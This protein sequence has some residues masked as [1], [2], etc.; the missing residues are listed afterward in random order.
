MSSKRLM[1]KGVVVCL[2]LSIEAALVNVP[3]RLRLAMTR[4]SFMVMVFEEV[5]C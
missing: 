2:S 1:V 4:V 3:A 5:H